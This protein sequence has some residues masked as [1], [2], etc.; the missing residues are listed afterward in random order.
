[1]KFR[2]ES[3]KRKL[4]SFEGEPLYNPSF[5][6]VWTIC[7]VIFVISIFVCA[8]FIEI[9][10]KESVSGT[11]RKGTGVILIKPEDRGVLQEIYVI[12][13]V[14]V[15]IGSD[16]FLISNEQVSADG[17]F[18]ISELKRL[19]AGKYETVQ[20]IEKTR[21]LFIA[22]SRQHEDVQ[23]EIGNEIQS[24]KRQKSLA[25]KS[26]NFGR[27]DFKRFEELYRDEVVSLSELNAKRDQFIQAQFRLESILERLAQRNADLS[28]LES[29]KSQLERQQ[30]ELDI[31]FLK[32]L[33]D[34]ESRISSLRA[35]SNILVKS[36]IVGTIAALNTRLG[37]TVERNTTLAIIEPV[38][39]KIR[40]YF[41]LNPATSGFVEKGQLVHVEVSSF[42]K[43]QYGTI[44]GKVIS[45]T[46]APVAMETSPSNESGAFR[47]IV[48]L[49]A[50]YIETE[51][52]NRPLKSGMA[53]SGD[54]QV[55][56]KTLLRWIFAP[57]L[58]TI[59]K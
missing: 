31:E 41:D 53:I 43:E 30:S 36:P 37:A 39:G 52:G 14:S 38:N 47:A 54:I 42:P 13:G 32:T 34:N 1:M 21:A 2:T 15:A 56:K 49:D 51:R 46:A 22:E 12:E 23:F 18:S 55:G 50:S 9:T 29:A 4:S 10:A 35:D 59:G 57:I 26:V 25:E 5:L 45:V 8:F 6:S 58:K 27:D 20:Q 7:A 11:L 33:R 16:L 40:A 44:S 28:R 48:E 24:L 3:F 17:D 19:E